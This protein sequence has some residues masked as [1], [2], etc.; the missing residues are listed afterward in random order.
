MKVLVK[1]VNWAVLEI[2]D[3]NIWQEKARIDNGLLVFVGIEKDD[4]GLDWDFFA[5]KVINLRVFAD[6]QGR[7]NYSVR[8]KGFGVML[9]P[10][11]TLCADAGK[12]SRPAFDK[13]MSFEPAKQAYE[14]LTGVFREKTD[15]FACAE[16]G[17]YMNIKNSEDGPVNIIFDYRRKNNLWIK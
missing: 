11:F 4:T 9:V 12:G 10:N 13:A 17:A 1:R 14:G 2:W 5:E 8:D 3:D 7:F 6:S 15:K 16:F